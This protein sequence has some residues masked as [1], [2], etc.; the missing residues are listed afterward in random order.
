VQPDDLPKLAQVPQAGVEGDAAAAPG[1]GA[2]SGSQGDHA[3]GQ[4][5]LPGLRRISSC[6]PSRRRTE[7]L[8]WARHGS[9]YYG[10]HAGHSTGSSRRAWQRRTL[11]WKRPGG[12]A[13]NKKIPLLYILA[14]MSVHWNGKEKL[15]NEYVNDHCNLQLKSAKH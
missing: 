2:A 5:L 3:A 14:N 1:G 9:C 11:A 15:S 7:D 13:I 10:V 12:L 4:N 6:C 8:P